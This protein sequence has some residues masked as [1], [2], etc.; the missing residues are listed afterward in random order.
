M[1]YSTVV[2]RVYPPVSS[3][4][5]PTGLRHIYLGN[6]ESTDFL[7]DE[8][9]GPAEVLGHGMVSQAAHLSWQD[10]IFARHALRVASCTS[11]SSTDAL[12]KAVLDASR[13]SPLWCRVRAP[14]VERQRS[15]QRAA[16]PLAGTAAEL[17]RL[18]QDIVKG[19][20]DRGKLGAAD[21]TGMDVLVTRHD[22][23]WW[24]VVP[25]SD[26]PS[27]L[28]WPPLPGTDVDQEVAAD[29]PSSAHRKLSEAWRWLGHT[30]Q[31]NDQVVDLG[32]APGGWTRVLLSLGARVTAVDRANLDAAV[33]SHPHVS[34][35]RADAFTWTWPADTRWL[36]CDVIAEPS[37]ILGV[38]HQLSSRPSRVVG[39]VVTIKL[40]APIDPA[41]LADVKQWCQHNGVF[42]ARA[43]QLL[44]NKLE[45]TVMAH[46]HDDDATPPNR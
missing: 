20:R 11:A 16:A 41:V 3:S 30:P 37:L 14:A 12:A 1:R 42:I 17:Q 26:Q 40:R 28:S 36:V 10:P 24:S 25:P 5:S 21:G 38:L 32:A 43:K 27:L 23:A 13:S 8:L 34:H 33:M 35:V 22:Q 44:A 9:G 4:R 29:A 18:L 2:R 45:F 46:R 31:P 7:V 15:A 39:A 6:P 19:R